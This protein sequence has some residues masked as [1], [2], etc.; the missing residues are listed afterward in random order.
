MWTDIQ[1]ALT[2]M[3]PRHTTCS[4][5]S[6]QSELLC[7]N[8]QDLAKLF[9]SRHVC[10]PEW[11][12]NCYRR[13]EH[14]SGHVCSCCGSRRLRSHIC[15]NIQMTIFKNKHDVQVQLRTVP[16]L[17]LGLGPGTP[18]EIFRELFQSLQTN[19]GR[20]PQIRPWWLPPTSS[21]VIIP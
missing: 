21:S 12:Q 1:N 17:S 18:T 10:P 15:G 2:V 7:V 3:Q 16:G 6:A 4:V 11:W 5:Q 19:A 20:V 9:I 14:L 13:F 8:E